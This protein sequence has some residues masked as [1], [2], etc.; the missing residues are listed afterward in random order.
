MAKRMLVIDDD[1]CSAYSLGFRMG[2]I[3]YVVSHNK[4]DLQHRRKTLRH[5]AII[6]AVLD[7]SGTTYRISNPPAPSCLHV[8]I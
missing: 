4:D 2:A 6:K 3:D 8:W 5:L 7:Y 1:S